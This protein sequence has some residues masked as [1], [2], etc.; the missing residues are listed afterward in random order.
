MK[1]RINIEITDYQENVF[2]GMTWRQVLFGIAGVVVIGVAYFMTYSSMNE[3]LASWV[4]IGMGLPCFLFGFLRPHKMPLEKFIALWFTCAF[5]EH[6]FLVFR[7]ENA[8]YEACFVAEKEKPVKGG[9]KHVDS[10]RK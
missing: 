2:M 4:A 6:R 5:L 7:S 8:L 3:N 9:R 10:K 1:K